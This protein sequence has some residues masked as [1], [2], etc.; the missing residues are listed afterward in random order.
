MARKEKQY[1]FIYK[2]INLLNEKYYYG[3]HSTND[4]NDGYLGSGK[5]LRRS[6]NK[7]GK[8]NHKREIIEFLPDRKSLIEREK[9]IVNLNEIA[10]ENCMN[11]IVGGKGGFISKDGVKK[12][13]ATTDNIMI[14]KYGDNW[15]SIIFKNYYNNLSDDEFKIK[16][17]KTIETNRKNGFNYKTMLNKKLS[18]E[19]KKKMSESSKG[20]GMGENNSQF[21]TCWITNGIINKKINKFENIPNG[22]YKGRII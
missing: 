7:Y 10:K 16:I 22:W 8:E 21:G 18:E 19:T 1:H 12:G 17:K 4:L 14:N 15:R 20:M 5:R 13:R 9:E 2:T 3:M 11:L 6:I